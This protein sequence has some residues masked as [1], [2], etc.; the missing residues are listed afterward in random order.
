MA[1]LLQKALHIFCGFPNQALHLG[2]PHPPH[3]ALTLLELVMSHQVVVS[4]VLLM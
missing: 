3:L 1:A 4:R 2:G